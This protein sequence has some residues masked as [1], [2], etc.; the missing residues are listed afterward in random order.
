MDYEQK[1]KEALERAKV[2]HSGGSICD[3]HLTEVIFPELKISEDERI[4]REIIEYITLYKDSL[5]DKEYNS[6]IAWLEKQ[7]KD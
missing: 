4:R 6:W 7:K 3:I 2:Y 5:C 1:Y